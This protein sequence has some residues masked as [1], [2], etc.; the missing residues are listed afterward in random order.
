MATWESRTA[1][2]AAA[3]SALSPSTRV[4]RLEKACSSG[5]SLDLSWHRPRIEAWDVFRIARA[6]R[7][8]SLPVIPVMAMVETDLANGVWQ[9]ERRQARDHITC[10]G[11]QIPFAAH[12]DYVGLET[13]S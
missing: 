3:R 11:P 9:N 5:A 4:M 10:L 8:V 1:S 2:R 7:G 13:M 6:M 12:G